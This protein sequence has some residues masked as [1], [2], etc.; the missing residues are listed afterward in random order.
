MSAHIVILG[1]SG[2][3]GKALLE[4]LRRTGS[5]PVRGLR[6]A[7]LDLTS[8]NCVDTLCRQ[9]THDTILIVTARARRGSNPFSTFEADIT[10]ATN[11]A[12]C[13]ARVGVGRCVYFSTTAVYGD[14]ESDLCIT[15]ETRIAPSSLYGIAKFASECVLKHVAEKA[16]IP[17]VLLRLCMVYGPG[18]TSQAYGPTRFI[19]SILR[20]G[21]VHLFGDGSEGRDYLF[22]QDLVQITERFVCGDHSGTFNLATGHSYSFQDLITCLRSFM[23]AGFE[24]IHLERDGPQADQ[25]LNPAKLLGVLPGFQFTELKQGLFETYNYFSARLSG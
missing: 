16:G 14:M 24:V 23:P 7:D 1:S 20:E 19:Q 11:V 18:D 25:R 8:P 21:R 2:F 10:I 22:I 15:E 12:S 17:L 9:L 6:S 4:Y 5:V 3:I 13:L